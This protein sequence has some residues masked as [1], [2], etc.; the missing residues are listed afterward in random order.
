MQV[1]VVLNQRHAFVC[2]ILTERFVKALPRLLHLYDVVG[3]VVQHVLLIGFYG[4]VF[5]LH[6]G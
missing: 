2:P 4:K 1:V 6:N 3:K 5:M